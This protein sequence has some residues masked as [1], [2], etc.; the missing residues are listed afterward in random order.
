MIDRN[1]KVYKDDVAGSKISSGY[2]NVETDK[3]AY[4]T[5]RIVYVLNT[6]EDLSV[7]IIIDHVDSN[8][9]NNLIGNL[10]AITRQKNSSKKSKHSN[11]TTGHTGVSWHS[12]SNSWRVSLTINYK[13]TIKHFYVVEFE[14]SEAALEAAVA[15]R[16]HLEI[17]LR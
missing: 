9:S 2:F 12:L 7:D 15:Y 14:S 8:P 4:R 10:Q 13:M 3:I 5:H 16:K 6:M 17:T 1:G 11:N